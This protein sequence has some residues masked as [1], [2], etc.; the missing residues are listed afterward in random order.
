MYVHVPDYKQ[1]YI[2]VWA[3]KKITKCHLNYVY[4]QSPF[5]SDAP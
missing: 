3:C 5:Q 1:K 4:N 2:T